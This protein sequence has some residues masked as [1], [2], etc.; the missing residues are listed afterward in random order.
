MVRILSQPELSS[1]LTFNK[2]LFLQNTR[3]AREIRKA[4][5]CDCQGGDGEFGRHVADDPGYFQLADSFKVGGAGLEPAH[6]KVHDPKSCAS[7][8]FRHPPVAIGKSPLNLLGNLPFPAVRVSRQGL[9]PR[10]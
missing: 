9:E 10:T 5:K 7:A 2:L 6:R 3:G 1:T 8:R 4:L